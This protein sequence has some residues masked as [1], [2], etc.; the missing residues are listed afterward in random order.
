MVV[1][2]VS[3]LQSEVEGC[4]EAGQCHTASPHNREPRKARTAVSQLACGRAPSA[5]SASLRYAPQ[6]GPP[7]LWLL[8]GSSNGRSRGGIV[9]AEQNGPEGASHKMYLSR[10]CS[11]KRM[12]WRFCLRLPAVLGWATS[13]YNSMTCSP[14]CAGLP[15]RRCP[16][17]STTKSINSKGT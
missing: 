4:V 12:T 16:V 10:F 13:Q 14:P 3:R 7:R 17:G 9:V 2:P 6:N 11:R 15:I 1:N 8:E 5:A